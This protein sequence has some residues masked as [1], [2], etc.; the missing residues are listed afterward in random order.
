M[1]NLE[2]N[3]GATN[4]VQVQKRTA[5]RL[6]EQGKELVFCP[7]KMYPFGAW[8][9]GMVVDAKRY[10]AEDISFESCVANFEYYNTSAKQ[11]MYTTFYKRSI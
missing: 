6:F 7:C 10:K 1:R 2:F 8:D 9:V 5:K 4:W 11:G 3:D